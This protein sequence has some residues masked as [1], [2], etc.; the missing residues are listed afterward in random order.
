MR[1]AI[2][3]RAHQLALPRGIRST[4]ASQIVRSCT[5][6]HRRDCKSGTP[7]VSAMTGCFSCVFKLR[8]QNEPRLGKFGISRLHSTQTFTIWSQIGCP[9]KLCLEWNGMEWGKHTLNCAPY[10]FWSLEN[11]MSLDWANLVSIDSIQR[12]HSQSQVR[13]GV[14]W[15]FAWNGMG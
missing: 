3:A 5:L 1:R 14:Q 2:R 7:S 11:K 10:L 8:E 13:L 15:S 4:S 6:Q 9:V 12:G